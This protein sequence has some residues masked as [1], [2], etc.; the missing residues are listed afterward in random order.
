VDGTHYAQDMV[1]AL[2]HRGPDG[3]GIRAWPEATLVHTRLS[4]I[5]LGRGR[6]FVANDR[7]GQLP[8]YY[9][10]CPGVFVFAPE[11]KGA[12]V[13]DG[14]HARLSTGGIINFLGAGY[15]FGD[16][17]LFEGVSDLEP[18]TLLSV[19]LRTLE[20]EKTRLWKMVYEPAPELHRRQATEDLLLQSILQAHQ[21]TLC[22]APVRVA[23]LL[24]GGWD[25][26]GMLAALEHIHQP[27]KL[28]LS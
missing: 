9:P 3:S 12:L 11:V 13:N 16:L 17:T 2:Q 1:H 28:A 19:N 18:S 24:S 26:R 22:D 15:C 25:S 21:A 14:F 10:S 8:L 5:D 23:I 20:L 7:L 4:I 6:M 27:P